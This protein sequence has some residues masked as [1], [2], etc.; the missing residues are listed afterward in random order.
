[1]VFAPTESTANVVVSQVNLLARVSDAKVVDPLEGFLESGRENNFRLVR[2]V[3][4]IINREAPRFGSEGAVE[5]GPRAFVDL[6]QVHHALG[7]KMGVEDEMD[8]AGIHGKTK[9]AFVILD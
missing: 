2:L 5:D 8:Q 4:P 9:S 1:M 6:V 3:S 7:R